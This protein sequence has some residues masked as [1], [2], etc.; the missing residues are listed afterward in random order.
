MSFELEPA[1]EPCPDCNS[2]EHRACPVTV[3]VTS[4]DLGASKPIEQPKP[5]RKQIGEWRN[6]NFTV[7]HSTAIACGHKID[8]RRFPSN[9]NCFDCWEAFFSVSPEGVA[10][11]HQMLLDGGTQAVISM[12][13]SK[14]TKMFGRFLRKKLLTEYA[15]K[16]VQAASGIEGSIL[17]IK[18]EANALHIPSIQ[19]Q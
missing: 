17:D 4:A 19:T 9:A 14:F 5:T 11:V 1:D 3:A 13:G 8:L 7:K 18:E 10:S 16:Q 6:A 15:S 12:Y 2:T